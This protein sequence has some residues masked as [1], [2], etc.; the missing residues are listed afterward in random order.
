MGVMT[1][2]TS[3]AMYRYLLI[4]LMLLSKPAVAKW[5][6]HVFSVMG[7]QAKVEFEWNDESQAQSLIKQ[8]VAEMNRIDL[9][10][11]PYKETSELSS[12]NRQAFKGP[13]VISQELFT[14]LERS[15]HFSKLTS[16][17]FDISFSS[18][19][20]LYDY[21]K[22]L[23]PTRSQIK[24]LRTA[25]NYNNIILD[26]DNLTVRFTD[27]RVRIDLGGIAKGHSVDTSIALLRKAGVKNAYINA[28]GDSR[29]IGNKNDRLW[30]IGVRHPRDDKK[31][32]VNLP[33]DEVSLS[34]SGDYERFFIKDGVRYHHIIDPKTGESAKGMQS[35]TILAGDSTTADALS[36]SIFV[37]GVTKG[38]ALVN[39]LEDVSAIVV[40]NNGKMFISKDLEQP[41]S[42][43]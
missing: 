38:M 28:G 1:F 17:A 30:Y 35:A 36:T 8:V 12:V 9:L 31:L 13:L 39:S 19:G 34:T 41:D 22:Q 15:I 4:I 23:K 26:K 43:I 11:S 20:Y 14:L 40:A 2:F 25:I 37:L 27:K 16:G 10:M 5:Y 33:L 29:L 42:G 32:L 6:N 7:T 3:N 21:R 18:V 24:A